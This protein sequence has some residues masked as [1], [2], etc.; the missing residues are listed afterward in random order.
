MSGN[1]KYLPKFEYTKPS[2]RFSEN[3]IAFI[4]VRL[5]SE[6]GGELYAQQLNPKG[7][8]VAGSILV[9]NAES[10]VTVEEARKIARGK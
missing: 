6:K 8:D 7:V 1:D 4:R 5:M 10:I 3:Q 2:G 9:C